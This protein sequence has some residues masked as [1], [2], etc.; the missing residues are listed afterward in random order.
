MCPESYVGLVQVLYVP[1]M[2]AEERVRAWRPA[3]PGV[4]EVLHAHFTEHAY[5]AHTHAYWTVLLIDTGGVSYELER[6]PHDASPRSLTLLPP[7]VP[8][9]GK[10]AVAGWVRQAGRLPRRAVAAARP[11]RCGSARADPGR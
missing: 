8:H 5:P 3:V 11:H 9:D 1:D 10:A 7:H 6:T 2:S 4:G